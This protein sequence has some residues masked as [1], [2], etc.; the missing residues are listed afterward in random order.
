MLMV[1]SDDEPMIV[2]IRKNI[3]LANPVHVEKIYHMLN[4]DIIS[5]GGTK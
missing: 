4:E 1:I 3:T 5:R 2:F